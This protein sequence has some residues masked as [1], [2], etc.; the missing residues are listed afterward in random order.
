[1]CSFVAPIVKVLPHAQVTLAFSKYLEAQLGFTF[2][3]S[4]YLQAEQ[5]SDDEN[6]EPT[7]NMM[8]TPD[9]YGYFTLTAIPFKSTNVSLSGIYTGKMYVPHYAGYVSNDDLIVTIADQ[10]VGMTE[11]EVT[12]FVADQ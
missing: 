5:W 6:L 11:G 2:Q 8:R 7:L 3:K 9:N 12:Q 10:G 1:M 4:K